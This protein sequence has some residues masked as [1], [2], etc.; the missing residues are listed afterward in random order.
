MYGNPEPTFIAIYKTVDGLPIPLDVYLPTPSSDN[1]PPI[2]VYIHSGCLVAN[3][4]SDLPRYL[5]VFCERDNYVLVSVNFRQVPQVK[6]GDCLRDVKDALTWCE[7][8]LPTL[9]KERGRSVDSGKV[10]VIGASSGA[11]LA[12]L[13]GAELFP[14][15]KVVVAM[16]PMTNVTDESFR[17]PGP[18]PPTTL[19]DVREYIDGPTVAGSIPETDHSVFPPPITTGRARAVAYL[20]QE[21][22]WTQWLFGVEPNE[23]AELD[24]WD[25][26][27]LVTAKWP[28]TAVLHGDID[29]LVQSS[30]GAQ[31]AAALA[32]AGVQSMYRSVRGANHFFD[33]VLDPKDEAT[34]EAHS[35]TEMWRFVAENLS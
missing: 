14:N 10:A 33:I 31:M 29:M 25:A 28:P 26:R 22:L 34:L 30:N 13:V 17:Q 4:S 15:V 12:L 9:I 6:F 8:T 23:R 7:T 27:K 1:A 32:D 16:Y 11:W 18:V 20:A 3:D 21:A 19:D 5:P 2:V 24:K 35:I